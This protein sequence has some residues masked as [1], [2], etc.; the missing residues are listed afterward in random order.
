MAD[1]PN[2]QSVGDEDSAKQDVPSHAAQPRAASDDARFVDF[3]Q[4]TKTIL[5]P[6][7]SLKLTLVLF[8]LSLFLVYAGTVAQD[9]LGLKDVLDTYFRTPIA[10]VKFTHLFPNCYYPNPL[11]ET[12]PDDMTFTIPFTERVV[13]GFWFPGGFTIGAM[14]ALNLLAAHLVRFRIQAKGRNLLGGIGVL[15][16]GIFVT[17]LVIKSGSNE[18]GLQSDPWMS[19][20][21]LWYFFMAGLAATV[22]ALFAGVTKLYRTNQLPSW[23][24]PVFGAIPLSLGAMLAYFLINGEEAQFDP[25]SMRIL[26]QLMKGVFAGTVML[27]GCFLLFNRRAGVVL[28]HGGVGLLMFNEFYVHM[29]AVESNMRMFEGET[30]N[31]SFELDNNEL[32]ISKTGEQSNRVFSVP[33]GLIRKG[34][35]IS[36]D[37]LPFSLE[38]VEFYKNSQIRRVE[39]TEENLA[40]RGAGMA[41]MADRLEDRASNES[42][43]N[44]AAAYVK[45][46]SSDGSDLGT[47]MLSEFLGRQQFIQVDGERYGIELRFKRYY[48]TYTVKLI[49][50]VREDYVG[51]NKPKDYSSYIHLTDATRGEDRKVRIWMN[52]PL[53]FAGETFY[54]ADHRYIDGEDWTGLQIVS[55]DGWMIPYVSCMIVAVG[56]FAQFGFSILRF[57]RRRVADELKKNDAAYKEADA[58]V[59]AGGSPSLLDRISLAE[60]VDPNKDAAAERLR[61]RLVKSVIPAIVI[62][63]VGGGLLLMGLRAS[64]EVVPDDGMNIQAFGDLPIVAGGRPKPFDSLARNA[65]MVLSKRQTVY[66]EDG[67]NL[68]AIRWL[69]DLITNRMDDNED[70][71]QRRPIHLSHRVFKIENLQVIGLMEL[72]PKRKKY[73]YSFS[74]LQPNLEKFEEAVAEARKKAA[75][76]EN[77][78]DAMQRS[79]IALS[80]KWGKLLSIRFAFDILDTPPLPNDEQFEQDPQRSLMAVQQFLA[81][82][83]QTNSRFKTAAVPMAVFLEQRETD[84]EKMRR[85]QPYSQAHFNARV[86]V[87]LSRLFN[88]IGVDLKEMRKSERFGPDRSGRPAD[89]SLIKL[90][91]IL[92]AYDGGDSGEFNKLVAQQLAGVRADP[93]T[94]HDDQFVSSSLM[95][96][97]SFFNRFA[98]FFW[99]AWFYVLA[100]VM[101]I[102]GW[103]V[104]PKVMNRTAFWTILVIFALHTFALVSRIFISGRPPVTNLYSSALFIGWGGVVLGLLFEMI[105]RM[106]IGNIIAAICGSSTLAIA[107]LLHGMSDTGDTVSVMQAV[108]DTQF[109]LATHVTC[110]T[111]GYTTTFVAGILG[112]LLILAG[113]CSPSLTPHVEKELG[114]MMYGTLCFAIL[115][116]FVGTVLGGLWADDSWGRFWG[117]D[118]K[119]NGAL[120]IVIWNALILHCRWDGIARERGIAALA[121]CGNICTSFSWF[122]VNQLGKGLHAY[123]FQ[124]GMMSALGWVWLGHVVILGMACIPKYAWWSSR[125]QRDLDAGLV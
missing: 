42:A 88:K 99:A 29:T 106:G 92:A 102:V 40:T 71:K 115:F 61:I 70:P 28:L 104:S 100:F 65:L 122:A 74:E 44:Y 108:L 109:W 110:I 51:T 87:Q 41:I 43:S 11:F 37:G 86:D 64:K 12:K 98:P 116:S 20:R 26:W 59:A 123:G 8:S 5:S 52:N 107:H 50:A 34:E 6:I 39:E 121:V 91:E 85:W 22:I 117:W 46:T 57:L 80:D 24:L 96:Y 72:D 73:L 56:L 4:I 68:P 15:V 95:S 67:P 97:E 21:T 18:E 60:R 78:L 14:L 58:L 19:W 1:Q 32:A 48:K 69:L 30:R 10:Q 89:E 125:H 93:P 25:S 35:V 79:L 120:I 63:T 124:D 112:M 66:V 119:E 94:Y 103:L 33:D 23:G 77:R 101:G 111:L 82:V 114:R 45:L 27:A 55:N 49:D 62:S 9:T 81:R 2:K 76:N 118:P 3:W 113:V 105:Y 84:P 38:I 13:E 54:Q 31:Y 47:L 16:A 90:N 7:S 17:W 83:E 53:R 36:K 75:E